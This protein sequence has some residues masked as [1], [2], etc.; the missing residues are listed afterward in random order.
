[1]KITILTAFPEMF[2]GFISTSIIKKA[3]LKNLV[4][5]ELVDVR[6]YTSNKHQRIDDTPF[7]GGAGMVMFYQPIADAIK[8]HKTSESMVILLTPVG[9][10]FKQE[11]AHKL[12]MKQDLILVCGHYEGYD[13]RILKLV[14]HCISIG[15]YVLTG[16][17]LAAMVVSDGVIRLLDGVITG[18]SLHEESFENGLLEYP[19]YTKPSEID[20][21][22]VPEV[23]LSGHHENIR[24]WRLK[25]SIKKT[26]YYRNDLLADR[27]LSNE[28]EEIMKELMREELDF[29]DEL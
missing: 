27:Q 17:E 12:K 14:D 7:G 16:G 18:E 19:Q 2:D 29:S 25:Q 22:E 10:T 5:F 8:A 11:I 20:G 6:T 23:L 1:M 13:E 24:K 9:H 15:D 28:E 4:A 21:Y 3:I 26:C